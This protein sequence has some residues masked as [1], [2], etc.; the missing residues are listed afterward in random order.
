LVEGTV[1][2]F[3]FKLFKTKVKDILLKNLALV[4]Q[5]KQPVSTIISNQIRVKI[6]ELTTNDE[7]QSTVATAI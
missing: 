5:S 3:R 1:D 7:L 2:K 6:A 4:T